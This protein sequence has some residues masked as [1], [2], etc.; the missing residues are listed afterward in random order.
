[1]TR[2]DG[3]SWQDVTPSAI[4]P[5]SRVTM[6]EASHFDA[7]SAYASVD[8]HQLQDFEPY[9]YRTRDGGRSWQ[10]ITTGLP[11][12]VY[13]HVVKEDP[14]RRGLLV[15]GTE[16]GAFVSL[17][18]GDSW[19]SLQLNLP[20]TSVRDFQIHEG[21]L[22]VG[23][24]GRGI[25][26]IDDIS[27]LRQIS[28]VVL[29]S[30]AY[31]FKPATAISYVQGDDNGTPV[32][33]DEPQAKN[34]P[35]GAFID[36]YLA[37]ASRTPVTLE[38]VDAKGTVVR[39]FS[40]SPATQ[41]QTSRRRGSGAAGGIS[42]VS[43]LWVPTPDVFSAGAGLHRA[44]WNPVAEPQATPGVDGG[45]RGSGEPLTGTFTARLNA[46]GKSYTQ[47]FEVKPDPRVK[48]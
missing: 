47:T 45:F 40:S 26:V 34:R 37:S 29:R 12:S 25:W 39:T 30:D 38:I 24:H 10:K 19:Q 43:P 20:V 41:R 2:D 3:A 11:A 23:T 1:V 33:K 36:Y 4:T 35:A 31:L 17:D 16:R 28:D 13:V 7:S 42:N 48:A 22:I 14:M 21:D 15:A 6:I 8:R 44:V 5:W 9:I 32:Q 27:P 18:D 46:G